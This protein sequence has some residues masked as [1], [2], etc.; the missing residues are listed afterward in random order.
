MSLL[1]KLPALQ[2]LAGDLMVLPESSK[3]DIDALK[4]SDHTLTGHWVGYPEKPLKGLGLLAREP[5]R[6]DHAER[7]APN[8][9]ME[10]RL[11]RNGS[12]VLTAFP[13]W[14]CAKVVTGRRYVGQLHELISYIERRADT[15]PRLVIGDFNSNSCWD[16]RSPK[17]GSHSDAVT[18]LAALGFQSAYH[19]HF[20]EQQGAETRST[21]FLYGKRERHF[22]I[23]FAFVS[24]SL[25]ERIEHVEIG[26]FETWRPH[27]DHTPLIL[28]LSD[29]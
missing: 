25:L 1:S 22:H 4:Q 16:D 14:T 9:S 27:S 21:F 24:A 3:H 15:G 8:L 29:S 20:S 12:H 5:Y 10:A 19:H 17:G 23:D 11:S 7:L 18:R 26:A 13:L 6:L 2:A 28:T